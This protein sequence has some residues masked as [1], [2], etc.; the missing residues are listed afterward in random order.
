MD[1]KQEP[2]TRSLAAGAPILTACM[3]RRLACCGLH[4]AAGHGPAATAAASALRRHG[5]I[6]TFAVVAWRFAG[7]PAAPLFEG[8][9]R[10]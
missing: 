9:C 1:S 5:N 4:A 8:D 7:P 10:R 3:L 2:A 6:C